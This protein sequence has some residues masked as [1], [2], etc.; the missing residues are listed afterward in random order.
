MGQEWEESRRQGDQDT[1]TKS[2]V[3]VCEFDEAALNSWLIDRQVDANLLCK[4]VR[5][6][7]ATFNP[8]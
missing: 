7:T 2:P 4:N 6:R 8:I 5:A 1:H 3:N